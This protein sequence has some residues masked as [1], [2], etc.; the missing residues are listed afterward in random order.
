MLFTQLSLSIVALSAALVPRAAAD[1]VPTAPGPGDSFNEGSACPIQW[2]LD[3][4]GT[5]TNF[6]I[7]LMTGSNQAMTPLMTVVS[8]VDGT[9]GTGKYSWTCPEVTPNS[10]FTQAGSATSWTTRFTIASAS[11]ETTEPTE[12]VMVDG[13]PVGWGTGRLS[14][15]SADTSAAASGAGS[16]GAVTTATTTTS[17]ASSS[18]SGMVTV[19]TT[20]STDPATSTSTSTSTSSSSSSASSSSASSSSTSSQ[21]V[22]SG[23]SNAA[24][25]SSTNGN[26]ASSLLAGSRA[27]VVSGTALVALASLAMFA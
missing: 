24:A 9:T 2:N 22:A 20:S 21:V 1:A 7:Q 12:T 27:V 16:S 4:T 14:G 17:S 10:A 23:S 25:K 5:W 11:G 3:T 13:K 15:A 18:P 19:V 8:G 26:G 6:T